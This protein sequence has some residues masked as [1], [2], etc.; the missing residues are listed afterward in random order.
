MIHSSLTRI[1]T[2]TALLMVA[3]S[4]A[5]A[6]TYWVHPAGSNANACTHSDTPLSTGAKQTINGAKG[7]VRAGDTLNIR[8]GTYT[9]Q[10]DWGNG[11]N[12]GTDGNPITIQAYPGET[13][14]WNRPA[15]ATGEAQL[16]IGNRQYITF[17]GTNG[18][19]KLDAISGNTGGH[20]SSV[21]DIDSSAG[22]VRDI[23][24]D[25]V[26]ITRGSQGL[27]VRNFATLGHSQPLNIIVKNSRIHNNGDVNPGDHGAYIG[28]CQYCIFERNEI[29]NNATAGITFGDESNSGHVAD[30]EVRY[31]RV[32]NNGRAISPWYGVRDGFGVHVYGA[33]N[34][35]IHHNAIFD[36]PGTS[37]SGGG[38]IWLRS[39]GPAQTHHVW[40]NT[41]HNNGYAIYADGLSSSS[42]ARNNIFY[43]STVG[44]V[45]I[46]SGSLIQSNNLTNNPLFSNTSAKDFTLQ[47]GSPA[48]DAGTSTIC[49]SC[50]TTIS[51][52]Q[53][54]GTAPDLGYW[55]T[56]SRSLP[57][58]SQP[59]NVVIHK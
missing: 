23:T 39:A 37:G 33:Q 1:W 51:I 38:G 50:P 56:G 29:Y 22:P 27:M 46:D 30:I 52:T 35:K 31:N 55:E 6:G 3:A 18:N 15:G 8:G 53:F 41:L 12:S 11:T 2:I 59:I 4:S 34:V 19:F 16:S 44:T 13:V 47:S 58:P 7:C 36:N 25:G 9:E 42:T 17:K 21:I 49:S 45:R 26:E 57:A 48:I 43:Q 5:N 28:K 40:N 54:N 24:L 20:E 10:I 14:I 32:Y